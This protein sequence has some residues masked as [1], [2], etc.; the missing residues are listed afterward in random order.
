MA[1]LRPDNQQHEQ[2]PKPES[3]T[4]WDGV[5]RVVRLSALSASFLLAGALPQNSSVPSFRQ[6]GPQPAIAAASSTASNTSDVEAAALTLGAVTVGGVLMRVI[7]NS[8][9]DKDEEQKR[10]AIECKRLEDAENERAKRVKRKKMENVDGE[11][12]NDEQLMSDLMKRLKSLE[13]DEQDDDNPDLSNSPDMRHTPIPDRGLGSAVLERPGEGQDVSKQPV[14]PEY[15]GD[16]SDDQ[17]VADIQP[18]DL[19]KPEEAE[20]LKRMWN[21]SSHDKE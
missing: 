9:R 3:Q 19:A 21:L 15:E 2:I 5:R 12:V 1:A 13:G 18:Q 4:V 16:Q 10:L 14:D 20:M 11:N 8:R 17:N 7:V 6:F